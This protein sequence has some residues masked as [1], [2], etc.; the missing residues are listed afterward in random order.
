[1]VVSAEPPSNLVDQ[2]YEASVQGDLWPDVID[3]V[4]K[5]S[6]TELGVLFSV[7]PSL[8]SPDDLISRWVTA[9]RHREIVDNF[10]KAGWGSENL[11]AER[12]VQSNHSG[13]LTDLDICT[14]EEIETHPHYVYLRQA[15]PLG[16]GAATVIQV[17]SGDT[18]I[19]SWERSGYELPMTRD[20]VN[21]LDSLRPHLARAALVATRLGL[22]RARAA[23][24]AL[25]ALGLPACVLAHNGRLLAA[26]VLFQ[27]MMPHSLDESAGGRLRIVDRQADRLLQEAVG[28]Y[29]FTAA[30]VAK[31]IPVRGTSQSV[32]FVVHL[33][34]LKRTAID[35]MSGADFVLIATP[36]AYSTAP[37]DSVLRGLFDLTAAEATVAR[38]LVEGKSTE[39]IATARDTSIGT[40]QRQL[41][42]IYSKT[43]VSRQ[44]ELVSVLAALRP[45]TEK[46]AFE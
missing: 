9:A 11:R 40:I 32:P 10:L 17:P 25:Q 5:Y 45:S 35:I 1:M 2:I 41:K 4:A 30:Q 3:R 26:N 44:S 24:E 31:S 29:R 23:A 33:L 36:V 21:R 12:L 34:P 8:T 15:G 6:G 16:N 43:G 37:S 19:M 20:E 13:F 46:G 27:G 18:L 7:T 22:E 39:A 42:A 14:A 38:A 28:Q